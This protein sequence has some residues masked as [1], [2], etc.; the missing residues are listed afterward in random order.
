MPIDIALSEDDLAQIKEELS[1][2]VYPPESLE[3]KVKLKSRPF[4]YLSS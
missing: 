2:A 3:K 1:R 4:H